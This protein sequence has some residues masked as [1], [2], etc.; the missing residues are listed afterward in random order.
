M[1]N[2]SQEIQG[3][4]D[5]VQE[6]SDFEWRSRVGDIELR[7]KCGSREGERGASRRLLL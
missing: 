3:G 1:G 7:A 5:F 6:I 4:G 2:L